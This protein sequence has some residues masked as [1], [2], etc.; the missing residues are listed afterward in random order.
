RMVPRLA[1]NSTRAIRFARASSSAKMLRHRNLF[2]GPAS[3]YFQRRGKDFAAHERDSPDRLRPERF[4]EEL[5]YYLDSRIACPNDNAQPD[6]SPRRAAVLP[7]GI[8]RQRVA[9]YG[10]GSRHERFSRP[11]APGY[12]SH[13]PFSSK[14]TRL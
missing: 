3:F 8:Y 5:A 6:C 13:G 14:I 4:A 7:R 12:L 2:F 11:A 10:R 9:R 1:G